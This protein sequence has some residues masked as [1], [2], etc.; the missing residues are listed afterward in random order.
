MRRDD[1]L[2]RIQDM[3]DAIIEAQEFVGGMDLST[4]RDDP[5]T[6]R[7]VTYNFIVLGEAVRQ[8]P[9]DIQTRYPAIPWPRM[10]GMRNL[11]AHEYRLVDPDILWQTVTSNLPPLIPLLRQ[12]LERES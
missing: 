7:A 10:R 12:V 3:L 9:P 11:I 2:V 5:K 8:I 4:F 1:W 6:I